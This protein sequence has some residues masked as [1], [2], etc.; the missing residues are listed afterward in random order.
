MKIVK[1]TITILLFAC[2]L[3]GC[4]RPDPSKP[5]TAHGP[6]RQVMGTF[7]NSISVARDKKTAELSNKA[8]FDKL[9]EVDEMMS[10][11]LPTSELSRVNSEAFGNPVNVSDELFEVLSKA[12]EYSRISDGAFDITIGPVVVLWRRAEDTKLKPTQEQIAEAKAKVGY[13]KMILDAENKTVR[14][15]VEGMRLDLGAIAKGY[16]IDMAVEAMIEAGATGGMVD[17]GGDIRCFG[18]PGNKPKWAIGLQDPDEPEKL[19]MVIE[20]GDN[21]IATS[22]DYQRFVMLDGEKFSHI[23]TPKKGLSTK[24]LTSV[25]VIAKTAI[26]T[27]A[28][29][30]TV[31]VMGIEKGLELIKTIDGTEGF[32][33]PS[34]PNEEIKFTDGF[35]SYIRKQ[36]KPGTQ[37]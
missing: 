34:D 29:A 32:V 6:S 36:Q 30:T 9:V 16:A 1:I 15:A 3:C 33:V 10:D 7:A 8:A 17:V 27:D 35:E 26:D 23:M 21:A 5:Y 12:V 22:G 25:T 4:E 14:F 37:E 2:L 24:G 13:K 18:K 19:L 11:Y 20:L 28:L 31:T